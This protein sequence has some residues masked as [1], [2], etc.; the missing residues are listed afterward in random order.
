ML[1]PYGK[2]FDSIKVVHK[3]PD[4]LVD[5]SFHFHSLE[6]EDYY[7]FQAIRCSDYPVFSM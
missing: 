7:V 4:I 5:S 3:I 1:Y 2:V 6:R